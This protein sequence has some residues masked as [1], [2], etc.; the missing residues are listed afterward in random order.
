MNSIQIPLKNGKLLSTTKLDI[1]VV[2]NTTTTTSTPKSTSTNTTPNSQKTQ[3]ISKSAPS[4]SNNKPSS[5]SLKTST[6]LSNSKSSNSLQQSKLPVKPTQNSN[7]NVR[8]S[9]G[10]RNNNI[11]NVNNNSLKR[12]LPQSSMNNQPNKKPR[13][14][15]LKTTNSR[16]II[17]LEEEFGM[18]YYFLLSTSDF[19]L[20]ESKK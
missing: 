2:K 15:Q 17:D 3:Q 4:S 11:G 6:P 14:E 16:H 20:Y 18:C 7:T 9:I 1:P 19:I 10:N 8:Q 13:Y 5:N 12:P